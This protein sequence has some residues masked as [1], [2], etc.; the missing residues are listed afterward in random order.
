MITL[1]STRPQRKRLLTLNMRK[2]NLNPYSFF[3]TNGHIDIM[4]YPNISP[5]DRLRLSKLAT[6]IFKDLGGD[7]KDFF[8]YLY[9]K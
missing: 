3:Y 4:P 6:A 1:P 5:N 9:S 7:I 8:S 2:Y